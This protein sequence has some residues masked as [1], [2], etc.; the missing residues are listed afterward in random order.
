MEHCT[1][2][3]KNPH[4][5]ETLLMSKFR[6]TRTKNIRTTDGSKV[7]L[8]PKPAI[9][10]LQCWKTTV[11]EFPGRFQLSLVCSRKSSEVLKKNYLIPQTQIF[12]SQK[13]CLWTHKIKVLSL[14]F[15]MSARIRV[16]II[17]MLEKNSV[18][19]SQSKHSISK[20]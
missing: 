17:R 3:K 9:S 19:V 1:F 10:S 11:E 13:K 2:V 15:K 5:T 12:M 20:K 8:A 16:K 4:N 14:S 6:R 18:T 7:F